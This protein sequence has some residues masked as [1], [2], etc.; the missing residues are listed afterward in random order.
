VLFSLHISSLFCA[1]VF[2]ESLGKISDIPVRQQRAGERV[3]IANLRPVSGTP[4]M[5]L[6]KSITDFIIVTTLDFCCIS[7]AGRICLIIYFCLGS[8]RP[9]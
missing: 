4:K 3:N 7:L 5:D 9:S 2:D 1:A 6:Q 8:T